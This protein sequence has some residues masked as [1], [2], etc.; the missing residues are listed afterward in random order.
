MKAL[1]IGGTGII[2]SEVS[3][4]L[5]DRGHTVFV[6]N[7]GR[8]KNMLDSRAKFIEADIRRDDISTMVEDFFDVVIDFISY[9]VDQ[10]QKMINCFS[11]RCKQFV[12]I[13]SATV[14]KTKEEGNYRECDAV[15]NDEWD[16]CSKKIECEKL[17]HNSKLDCEFSI[18][19]P[20]V[21]YGITRVP[22]QFCPLEYYTIIN[23]LINSKPIPLYRANA[24]CTVTYSAEFA[25][26]V[27]G[28]LLN[29]KAYGETFHI[30]CSHSTSWNEIINIL[31]KCL[32][33]EPI[34]IDIPDS[35]LEKGNYVVSIDEIKGDKARNMTFDNSKIREAVPEFK[36]EIQFKDKAQ[37]IVNYYKSHP[38]AQKVNYRWDASM[39]KLLSKVSDTKIYRNNLSLS[40]YTKVS[41]TNKEKKDYLIMRYD[42]FQWLKTILKH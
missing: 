15:G 10:L 42:V 9:D 29:E 19:R 34:I 7:R 18:V 11:S 20:Y 30:T 3:K 37:D 35:V 14:Y 2:S 25:I 32:H 21:T 22:Y 27:V 24:K 1:L 38:E 23:R 33:V 4:L 28:L 8:R 16:Y 13:S 26:G 12:F 17:L 5:L 36:G 31:G 41:L 39:D 6:V 40:G